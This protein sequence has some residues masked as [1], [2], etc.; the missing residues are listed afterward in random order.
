MWS[1]SQTPACLDCDDDALSADETLRVHR[2]A[3][4]VGR[5]K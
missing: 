5:L 3:L 4:L 1:A 2:A